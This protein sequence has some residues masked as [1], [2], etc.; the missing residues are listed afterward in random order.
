MEKPIIVYKIF[1]LLVNGRPIS[2]PYFKLCTLHERI[3]SS[4]RHSISKKGKY[5]YSDGYDSKGN[6][7]L[8]M[9][10]DKLVKESLDS[11]LSATL[12]CTNNR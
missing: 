9:I 12:L 7:L 10:V 4:T 2:N 1:L 11:T 8:T 5:F 6:N 3:N